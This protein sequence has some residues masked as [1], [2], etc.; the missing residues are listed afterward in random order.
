MKR[1][2]KILKDFRKL[3]LLYEE[4]AIFTAFDTETTGLS[5]T[6]CRIIEIGAIKF[7]KEGIIQ[8]YSQ[9]FNPQCEIPYF[10]SQLTHINQDMVD[11]CKTINCHLPD[12]LDMINNTNLIAHNAQFDLNF[13]N[14]E[15]EK[16]GLE[17]TKNKVID[18]LQY[19]KWAFPDLEKHKLDFLAD[20]FKINKGSSHRAFDDAETCRQLFLKCNEVRK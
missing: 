5:P 6:N 19:S 3:H 1:Q 15:C 10:I 14:A 7:S 4:G 8:K 16:S 20:Y 2:N 17:S 12:F 13:L 11:C 9:L 18:T